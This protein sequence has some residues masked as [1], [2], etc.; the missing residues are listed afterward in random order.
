VEG[1]GS[2][3]NGATWND[4]DKSGGGTPW[5]SPGGDFASSPVAVYTVGANNSDD[6]VNVTSLAQFWLNNS[7]NNYGVV[8]TMT[9]TGGQLN[10]ASIQDGGSNPPRLAIEY[11]PGLVINDVSVTE[12]DSG[13]TNA[14]FNVTLSSA[15][16]QTVT[17]DYTTAD[18]TAT[19]ADN[20]YVAASGTLT[21]TPGI[22]VQT[23]TV[24]VN[25][26]V[27]PE[28]TETFLVN[29]S[30]PVNAGIA[31]GQGVGTIV[32][33]VGG[34]ILTPSP[35]DQNQIF[36]PLIINSASLTSEAAPS[37][38]APLQA[39]P[40]LKENKLYLPLILRSE[41]PLNN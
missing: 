38:P 6:V 30:N 16:T 17:V 8:L 41:P 36:L 25:G 33:D 11:I 13:T 1:D 32:Q 4:R 5:S 19:T 9:G 2:D 7:S 24:T 20:D 3:T 40:P 12:G 34:F 27:N 14:V 22:T 10:Y 31:D 39:V 35:G 21:F 28:S 29:L 37:S 18:N 26:D 15:A 23:I